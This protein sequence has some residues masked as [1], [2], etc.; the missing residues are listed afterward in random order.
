VSHTN[1]ILNRRLVA[2]LTA[3]SEN[4]YLSAIRTGMVSVVPL[5]IIGG[6]F[7]IVSYFPNARWEKFIQP[8]LQLLQ[9][10]VTAT[11]GVLAIF[12]CFAIG[13]D[14]GK[15]LKQEPIVSAAMATIVFLMLQIQLK[16]LTLSMD[17]LGSKGLFTAIIVSIICVRVRSFSR[18]KALSS[19]CRKMSRRSSMNPFCRSFHCSSSWWFSGSFR[20]VL[21]VDI[22]G[23]RASGVQTAG[24]CVEH[25]ARN[26]RICLS[27]YLALVRGNQW[28]QR[29]GCNRRSDLSPIPRCERRGDDRRASPALHHGQWIFHHVRQR[30][31]HRRD[32]RSRSHHAEFKRARF[33]KVSRISLP[34]QI[35]QINEPIFFGFPIVLNPILMIPYILNALILTAGTYLLMHWNM[36]NKPFVNVPGPRRRS[37]GITSSLAAIGELRFGAQCPLSS[38]CWFITRS[39]KPRNVSA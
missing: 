14:L 9:I 13:Y 34:T 25:A 11:F 18:T 23:P 10:P 30:R 31:R 8:H 22:N 32:D 16:D 15:R 7:M 37:S 35:F 39:P 2:A 3:L 21:G 27:R 4:T 19:N 38:P 17:G 26:P 29:N 1:G 24:V 5:T 36:I 33:R 12:V 6:V 20:F 28:R